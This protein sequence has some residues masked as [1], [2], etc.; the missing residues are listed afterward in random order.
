MLCGF[1][2]PRLLVRMSEI[3][4]HSMIART[5]PPA[6]TPAP[7]AAGFISTRPAPCSPIT[8]CGIVLPVSGTAAMRRRAAST[9]LRTASDTSFALPVAN[10]TLPWPSP[11]ATNALN[12]N[13]RPPFTPF[14]T[15]LIAMTFSRS[16]PPSRPPSPRP[17]PPRDRRSPSRPP[18]PGPPRP[19]PPPGPP[20]P[21]P[22]PGP[23]R[24]P[25]PGPPRPPR[26][27]PGPPRPPP[28]RAPPERAE[29]GVAGVPAAGVSFSAIGLVTPLELEAALTGA[30][31]H[32]LHPAVVL[33]PCAIEHDPGNPRVFRARRDR[34]SDQRRLLRLLPL[35]DHLARH[36]HQRPLRHVIHQLRGDVFR[37]A[38]HDEPRTLR[39][40]RPLLADP[41]V[42]AHALRVPRLRNTDAAHYFAPVLPAFR[43]ICSLRYLMPLPLYGSGGRKLR[44]SAATSPTTSLVAPSITIDVG[45]GAVSLMPAGAR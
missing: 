13:R 27:P 25:P 10:P 43:R 41:K 20:R 29:R 31:R 21:P 32:R 19:P 45:C 18:P 28:D 17:S 14:A 5:A 35:G 36:G 38:I 11:T 12:E 3:P 26:P 2:D 6:M 8:S 9:A 24:P 42:A 37:R 22:P 15:R 16:S 1:V 33:V 34:P 39:S 30:I 4:A 40:A 44:S 23:P 7:G